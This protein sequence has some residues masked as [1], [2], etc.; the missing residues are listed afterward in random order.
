MFGTSLMWLLLVVASSSL[1]EFFVPN[2]PMTTHAVTHLIDTG[3]VKTYLIGLGA[4]AVVLLLGGCGSSSSAGAGDASPSTS[5]SPSSTSASTSPSPSPSRS[6][7]PSA[8]GT[9]SCV[10]AELRVSLS[11]G[12][13]AAGS[14]FYSLRLT[15]TS[16]KPCRTGGFG[17]VSLVEAPT[18]APIGAPADRVDKSQVRRLTL[19]P[20]GHAEATL[21]VVQASNFPRAACTP[22]AAKGLRVYPPDETRSAFVAH[23]MT[24]CRS[25]RTHLLSLSPYRIGG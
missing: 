18:G 4:A 14:T 8:S 19:R 10:L 16:R 17:G 11:A 20:G 7:S 22:V 5:A 9:A 6:A 24:A 1:L 3:A 12:E 2:T 21:R 13:G 25:G 15:N 23:P